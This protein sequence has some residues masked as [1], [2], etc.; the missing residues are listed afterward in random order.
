M[1]AFNNIKNR[2]SVRTFLKTPFRQET[3][4]FIK[5]YLEDL[6]TE[7]GPFSHT[8][9]ISTIDIE[10][11]KKV[12]TYGIIKNPQKYIAATVV[13]TIE[14]L[15]DFGYLFE[16]MILDFNIKKIGTCWMAGTFKRTDFSHM[17]FNENDVLP[18]VTPIGYFENRR[19][20]ENLMRKAAKS[21]MRL[22]YE[23]LFFN[24]NFETPMAE[25]QA[26]EAVR[27]GPSASNKQPWR[28][29]V[30]ED[31]YHLYLEENVKYN[32]TLSF[33]MQY[34]DMGIAMYHLEVALKEMEIEKTWIK[35]NPNV[36]VPNENYIYVVSY[37]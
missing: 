36:S 3:E 11:G 17:T 7:T 27:L 6:K 1:E 10:D 33:K 21:D 30:K 32:N 13:N 28:I 26:L 22:P 14:G 29:L 8:L 35:E 24:E 23:T 37:K 12:G 2:R 19:F 16:K 4:D 5:E 34:L 18:A 25:H 20:F 9:N 15:M 31:T